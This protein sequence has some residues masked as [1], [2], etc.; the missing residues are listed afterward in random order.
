MKSI[1]LLLLSTSL[2]FSCGGSNKAKISGTIKNAE[3][4]SLIFEKID[5]NAPLGIDTIKLD[6]DGA[7]EF[8]LPSGKIDFY[9]LNLGDNN[10]IVLC[11]DSTNTNTEVTADGKDLK[12]GYTVKGSKNSEIIHDYFNLLNPLTK[13]RFD[14]E[15]QMRGINF[16]DTAKVMTLRLQMEEAMQKISEITHDYIDK[17]P[18]SP[19]LIIMQSFLNP[20]TELPYFKKIESALVKSMPNSAYH[21]QISTYVSQIEY[22]LQQMSAQKEMEGNL[23]AGTAMPDIKLPNPQGKEISLSSLKGKVVLVDFWASWCRPC[24]AE[25]PNVL[26]LYDKYN[27]KGFEVFSVSL[28]EKKDL[29]I[30]AIK[31]DGLKWPYHVS[32]LAQWNSV[33]VKQF[34]ITGIPF[35]LLVDKQGNII[36]KGLRGEALESKL[37]EIFGS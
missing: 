33:V 31:A 35:T 28:D 4:K 30:A 24:R 15:N 2:L 7:F 6:K 3:G 23:K 25:S 22:Q 9:R 18:E 12:S 19:A 29:W 32:D 37:K 10:F 21:N 5:N 20:E 27:K 13:V 17:N 8:I 14:L 11:L 36:E 16:G 1:F 26:R 34:G